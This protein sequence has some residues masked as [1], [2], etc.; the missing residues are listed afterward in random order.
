MRVGD[1]GLFYRDDDFADPWE[2]HDT[3]MLQHGFGRSGNMYRGWVPHLSR[4][5]RVIRMDLRGTGQSADPGPDVRFTLESFMADFIGL[6]DALEI[7]RVHYVGE[8]LGSILGIA[9]AARHPERVKSLTL[10]SA[11]VRARPE[12]TGAVNAVGYPS[13]PEAIQALGMKEW[14]LRSRTATG[15]LTGNAAKD[16]WFAE[17]CGRTPVHVAQALLRFVPTV[18]AQPMLASVRASTLLLSPGA[19]R[20][21]DPEE[22]QAIL[23]AIPDAR[24]IRYE[25]AKHID[26]Y[27]KPDRYARDTREFLRE[28]AR[29]VG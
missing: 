24:Q 6:L 11:I 18:S 21:T 1:A 12:K 27:L 28:I 25:D 9:L 23:D 14:W 20:H 7:E 3:V 26:C 5:F 10:V 8:S 2:A 17:E 22:Q 13:W 29:R 16:N 4:D 15:E 19:S